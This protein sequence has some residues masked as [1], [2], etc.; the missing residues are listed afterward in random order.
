MVVGCASVRETSRPD[1]TIVARTQRHWREDPE[2]MAL[3]LPAP[4]STQSIEADPSR[5]A[6]HR[7]KRCTYRR[8]IPS[9]APA[10][11]S[12]RSSACT[13]TGRCRSPWATSIRRCRS[14]TRA[15]RRTSSVP[16]R[17]DL[18]VATGR[19][20]SRV[21]RSASEAACKPSSVP[22]RAPRR[23]SSISTAGHPTAHAADPRAGQRTS[24]PA[25]RGCALLFG[26]APGRVCRVSLRPG[27]SRPASSLWH[28]SSPR[29]GRA[30]PAALRCGARTFL[31]SAGCPASAR[32][33]GRLAGLQSV[34][35]AGAVAWS[36]PDP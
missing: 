15:R 18:G 27:R 12:T 36:R 23:R 5:L 34:G 32:P 30:L 9:I 14:A 25:N 6:P 3:P 31:T 22:R 33:S 1:R 28:W 35:D 13:R 4:A 19:A 21:E 29:G 16:T 8:L 20:R 11:A 2:L 24:P 17:T 10:S 26:L 7:I